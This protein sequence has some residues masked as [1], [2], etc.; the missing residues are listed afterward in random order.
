MHNQ[1]LV[2]YPKENVEL[3]DIMYWYQEVDKTQKQKMVDERCQFL[4]EIPEEEIPSVL[5]KIKE[6]L[7]KDLLEYGEMI[8]YRSKHSLK[9]FEEKYNR[10]FKEYIPDIYVEDYN[11]LKEYWEIKDLPINHP[12]QIR[13]IKEE[14]YIATDKLAEVYIPGR[15]YGYFDNPYGVW[16]YYR[17]VN[18][19]RFP[20]DVHFLIGK[21]GREDNQMSLKELDVQKTVDNIHEYTRVWED[22]IFCEK[23]ADDTLLYTLDD[24]RF[25]EKNGNEHCRVEDLPEVL[26]EIKEKYGGTD[27]YTVIALD[28]HW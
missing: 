6:K 11:N 1:V 17:V 22:I 3:E 28:Y 13:L 19:H 16:D 15:G 27:E 7:E 26:S 20:S 10:E 23:E 4:L 24:I 12:R 9:E 18:E 2:I 5:D 14:A 25:K 21:T 8:Q